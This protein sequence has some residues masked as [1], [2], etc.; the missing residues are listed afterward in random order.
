VRVDAHDIGIGDI[1]EVVC[2]SK[3]TA[4]TEESAVRSLLVLLSELLVCSAPGVPGML[5]ELVEQGPSSGEWTLDR[6]RDDLEA[7]LVPLNRG[8]TRRVL[9]RLVR[10]AKKAGIERQSK[11]SVVPAASEIDAQFDALMALEAEPGRPRAQL[12]A[13]AAA[14]APTRASA[15]ASAFA[16][17]K[18]SNAPAPR[19]SPTPRGSFGSSNEPPSTPAREIEPSSIPPH[20]TAQQAASLRALRTAAAV[21]SQESKSAAASGA[22]P[23]IRPSAED[24]PLLDGIDDR[25]SERGGSQ[26]RR[27]RKSSDERALR[28]ERR[29]HEDRHAEPARRSARH[30]ADGR[31]GDGRMRLQSRDDHYSRGDS[32]RAPMT[33]DLLADMPHDQPSRVPM[34]I[35][36]GLVVA[37]VVLA[38]M[39]FSLGQ[40]GARRVL[41]LEPVQEGPLP[42]VQAATTK[43]A[44]AAGTLQVNS[45]PGRAQVFLFVGNGPATA[46]DLP[47]GVAQEFVAMAEGYAPTRAVVPADAQ[48]EEASGQAPQYELAMQA[49]KYTSPDKAFELGATLLPRDVGMPS[50]R[51]GSVR[52]ITTPKGAKVYQLIGFTPDVRVENL[53]IDSG[54]EVLVYLPGYGLETRRV[55]PGDFKDQQGGRVADLS[56]PLTAA[57]R[58]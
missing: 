30:E 4:A 1:G 47:I 11:P 13:A 34:Y 45:E 53:P 12:R 18:S 42:E 43:P 55:E 5:L 35:G 27:A 56:V 24:G 17:P 3:K 20:G 52:V 6:L 8:A 36:G 25:Q 50:G 31:S 32:V 14:P 49:G 37:A 2:A 21:N 16:T 48:W 44:R 19:L 7:S 22:R 46:T 26:E 10:E 40:S 57:R 33:D 51:L 28:G 29:E 58:R 38:G 41:G 23:S 39:Y 54:Y 9:A 15:S